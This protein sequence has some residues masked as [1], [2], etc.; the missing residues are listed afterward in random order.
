MEL[1]INDAL[2]RLGIEVVRSFALEQELQSVNEMATRLD[3]Q[4][5]EAGFENVQLRTRIEELEH[6]LAVAEAALK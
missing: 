3:E 6:D 1:S 2:M 5:T 4:A